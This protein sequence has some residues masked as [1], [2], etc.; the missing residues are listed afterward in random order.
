[1]ISTTMNERSLQC[2]YTV[3][4]LT[5]SQVCKALLIAVH[6]ADDDKSSLV[7]TID[8]YSVHFFK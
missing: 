3:V 8:K 5:A 1:M 2:N 7:T 6:Q 4:I